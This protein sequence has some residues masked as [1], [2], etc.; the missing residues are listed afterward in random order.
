MALT[1]TIKRLVH[2]FLMMLC[3]L[4]ALLNG[5]AS[6]QL[7]I[8]HAIVSDLN[9]GINLNVKQHKMDDTLAHPWKRQRTINEN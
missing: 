6:C 4:T 8:T 5:N 3:L 7:L 9:V 1:V 2:Y